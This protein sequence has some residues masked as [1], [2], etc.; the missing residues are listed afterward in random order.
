MIEIALLLVAGVALLYFGAEF[1]I[2]GGVSIAIGFGVSPLIIG[3]TL[4]AM[5]TSAPELVVSVQ[6]ALNN[7]GDISI[8][9]VVGSNICNI[10]LILGLSAVIAPMAVNRKVIGFDMPIL[11][12]ATLAM[13][14]IGFF[15]SGFNRLTGG[16]FLL[17]LIVYILW[18]IRIE[19]RAGGQVPDEVAQAKK[20]PFYLSAI[21]VF[22]GLGALVVGGKFMV[23][24]AVSLG[25]MAGLSEAIIGLT[26]VAVGTSLP[27]LATSV[28]A[29]CKKEADIAI[30]NVVGSNLFNILGIM[31]VAPLLRPVSSVGISAVDW[32]MLLF[33][34]VVLLPLMM[35]GKRIV[36][37][38][39]ILL[40]AIYAMYIA[41]LAMNA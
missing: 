16:V 22:G 10:L 23:D 5:A 1:L 11:I 6:A 27:E 30:G 19:R 32:G 18:N 2:R 33:A 15:L 26:I 40:L 17:G 39:G 14:A 34:S 25:R 38:E 12:V 29:A 3:L 36:R 28:V 13:S 7:S 41:F 9:N 20:L 24:G 21:F 35:T 31:G 8:G 37:N 4:V